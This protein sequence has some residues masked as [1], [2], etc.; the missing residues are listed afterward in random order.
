MNN[1]ILSQK[2]IDS[3][4]DRF[5]NIP[6]ALEELR[7]LESHKGNSELAIKQ[8]L[9]QKVKDAG[10]L[11]KHNGNSETAIKEFL[12]SI[13][14]LGAKSIFSAGS[15]FLHAGVLLMTIASNDVTKN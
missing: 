1:N 11:A 6:E 7:V 9:M 5:Q 15:V 8:L 4:K 12:N 2:E 3:Y 14:P 13:N 10:L